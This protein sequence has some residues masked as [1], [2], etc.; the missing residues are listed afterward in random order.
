MELKPFNIFVSVCYPPDTD[1][2]GYKEEMLSKPE[3]TKTISESGVIVSPVEVAKDI[4]HYSNERYYGISTGFDGWLIKQVHPGMSPLNNAWEVC[5]QVMFASP[6]R[7]ISVLFVVYW[8]VL[9]AMS[10]AKTHSSTAKKQN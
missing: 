7:F 3:L 10:M 1:T 8:D 9:V 5:Q 2:P 4:V 6:I